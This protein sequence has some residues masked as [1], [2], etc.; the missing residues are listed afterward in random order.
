MAEL[1][2]KYNDGGRG[3]YF[4]GT[5]NDCV[6]RALAIATKGD[7]KAVYDKIKA[8]VGYTPRNGIRHDDTK[9]VLSAFGGVWHPLMGIGTGCKHH[10][11]GGEI[12]M[13][14]AVVCSLSGHL[15]AVVNGVNYDTFDPSRGGRRCVYG[16]WTFKN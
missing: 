5:A 15:T 12:P 1:V 4:K 8:V 6:T 10:L 13:N 7:Y 11:K 3:Q 9:K 14:G 2:Y 16:Y